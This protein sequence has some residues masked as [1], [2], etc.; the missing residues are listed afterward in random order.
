MVG[1]PV[2]YLL[3][4]AFCI[5]KSN[6]EERATHKAYF[7]QMIVMLGKFLQMH[8][9]FYMPGSCLGACVCARN[10]VELYLIKMPR[11]CLV[12]G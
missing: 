10:I 12:F 3:G 9:L 2:I 8:V 11:N 6:E 5:A 1:F 4:S 7:K